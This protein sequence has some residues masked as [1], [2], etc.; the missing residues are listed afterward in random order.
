LGARWEVGAGVR[1]FED[2]QS[3]FDATAIERDSFNSVDPRVYASFKATD[4]INIYASVGS[5]FRSGGFNRGP[6][7]NYEPESLVSYELGSKG[8]VADGKLAYEI[9][10]FYSD[11]KDMLRRGIVYVAD[12]V[13]QTQF[14][15]TNLGKVEV[16]GTEVGLTWRPTERLALNAT[17]AYM[18]S[19]VV[20][21]KSTDATN[22]AGDPVDYVPEVS[23]SL[24]A[25][26]DFDWNASLPGYFRID[27]NY[28]D[29]VSY[30]DRSSFPAGNVPQFSDDLSLLAARIGV[31]IGAANIEVFGTNLTNQNKWIDPYHDWRNANRTRPREIGLKVGYQF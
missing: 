16:K 27:Y 18:D 25:F 10:V 19:E 1:Y 30:I 2:R 21:V 22:I 24:G 26:Y 4:D 29:K 17:A 14:L 9:A 20:E 6:L 31:T 8:V 5:G 12:A 23:Y 15:T 28:R 11:Y 7:P 3:T 13:P